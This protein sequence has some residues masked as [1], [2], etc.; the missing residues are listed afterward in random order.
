MHCIFWVFRDLRFLFQSVWLASDKIRMLVV[1]FGDN[2]ALLLQYL[3]PFLYNLVS[4]LHL[5]NT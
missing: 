4:H 1:C 5:Y 2:F 3:A